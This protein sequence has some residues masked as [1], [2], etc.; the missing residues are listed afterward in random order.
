MAHVTEAYIWARASHLQSLLFQLYQ[1]KT[2]NTA[3]CFRIFQDFSLHFFKISSLVTL[4]HSSLFKKKQF[5]LLISVAEHM[6]NNPL[7]LAT[8]LF[9]P[10]VSQSI[11][12]HFNSFLLCSFPFQKFQAPK[13]TL[14]KKLA[15]S[16]I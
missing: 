6:L 3:R 2:E 14:L 1:C 9:L 5:L 10:K 13:W 15:Y 4:L 16:V 8:S 12:F 11:Y 7:P